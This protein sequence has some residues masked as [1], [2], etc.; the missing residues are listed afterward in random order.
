[1]DALSEDLVAKLGA[2]GIALDRIESLSAAFSRFINGEFTDISLTH[3]RNNLTDVVSRVHFRDEIFRV[4]F[5]GK[6]R[7]FIMP[8]ELS[9]L[10]TVLKEAL[11]PEERAALETFSIE[12]R[13]SLS[14]IKDA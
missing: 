11:S 3:L 2:L 8:P 5:H 7:T 14:P 10:I 13:V 12:K 4:L 6:P 1:M 9:L